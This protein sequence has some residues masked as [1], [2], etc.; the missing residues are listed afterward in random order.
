MKLMRVIASFNF[1]I[2][3]P[4]QRKDELMA[5][6]VTPESNTNRA[7]H[8]L[9]ESVAKLMQ[10]DNYKAALRLRKKMRQYSFSNVYL[11]W[12]QCPFA[13]YVAGYQ[14]WKALGRQ[15]RKGE[16]SIAIT[17]PITKKRE[18]EEKQYDLLGY[19]TASVFDISQTDGDALEL[20]VP[21]ILEDSSD[22]IHASIN[23]LETYCKIQNIALTYERLERA[24]GMYSKTKHS[25][26][27]RNDL[28]PLQTLKTFIH[29]L[30]HALMHR[31]TNDRVRGELEAE[32]CAFLVCDALGL[33]SSQYSFPY[34]I[35]W[36]TN[37]REIL[38]AAERAC[39]TADIIIK[40][41]TKG[42]QPAPL[43]ASPRVPQVYHS[44]ESLARAA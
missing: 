35:N 21:K 36:A 43:S 10:S 41:L 6:K 9:A 40:L 14:Q 15:V 38:P 30:A 37:P 34:L 26:I 18:G 24:K 31:E 11:I 28:P 20:P 3:R 23:C 7:A 17:A 12:L 29:E 13:S 1:V 2:T 19:K 42:V 16:T 32:S 39:K 33:D 44:G 5:T 8:L 22:E 27:L 25:I 4:L